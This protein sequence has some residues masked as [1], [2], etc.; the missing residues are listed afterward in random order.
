[1]CKQISWTNCR[2]CELVPFQKMIDNGVDMLMT[3]HIQYPQVEKETA[4]SKKDGSEIQ[5][6]GNA[7]QNHI[8]TDL[9]SKRNAL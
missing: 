8:I 6:P 1:M 2:Q 3:A 9:V 7:F 5:S 4:I